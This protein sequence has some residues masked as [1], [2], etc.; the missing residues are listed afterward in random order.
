MLWERDAKVSD[1]DIFSIIPDREESA[2]VEGTSN[3]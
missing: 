2:I 3:A 1:L